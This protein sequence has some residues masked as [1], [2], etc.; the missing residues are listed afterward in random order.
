MPKRKMPQQADATFL[1]TIPGDIAAHYLVS[2]L[3]QYIQE[4]VGGW[5]GA[6]DPCEP[7]FNLKKRDVKVV[8]VK[9]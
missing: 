6:F 3:R 8:H 1:V 9:S 7:L 4:A 2:D 5:S